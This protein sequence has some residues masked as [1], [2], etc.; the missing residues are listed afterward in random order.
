M[1]NQ[2]FNYLQDKIIIKG[3]RENNLKNIDVEIPK[4]KLVVF[5][6]ISGSGKTSLVQNILYQEGKRI[7]LESLNFYDRKF[8]QFTKKPDINYISGLA[9]VINI[10]QK[11]LLII[12]KILSVLLQKFIIIYS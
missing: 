10:E 11:K 5:T 2:N 1:A 8:F 3:A 9:P 12:L 6:G 7:Y 4:F